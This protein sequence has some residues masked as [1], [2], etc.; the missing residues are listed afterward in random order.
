MSCSSTRNRTWA[1][2]L[3]CTSTQA[4]RLTHACSCLP[5]C[6]CHV[7]LRNAVSVSRGSVGLKS[8]I[9]TLASSSYSTQKFE[10]A[11]GKCVCL[12]VG[13]CMQVWVLRQ[14]SS[15]L[16]PGSGSC[17]PPYGGAGDLG[18]IPSKGS[19]CS[20]SSPAFTASSQHFLVTVDGSAC[21]PPLTLREYEFPGGWNLSLYLC[22]RQLPITKIPLTL[23][24]SGTG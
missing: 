11:V 14:A 21:A 6:G 9:P 19:A 23:V 24:V 7:H 4:Y 2:T 22:A 17:E 18:P 12:C 3:V 10:F 20:R 8:A 13:M 16:F 1:L 5:A 15:V